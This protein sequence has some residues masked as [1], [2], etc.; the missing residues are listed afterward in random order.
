MQPTDAESQDLEQRIAD[1][2]QSI[3]E[4]NG[5]CH[6]RSAQKLA[7]DLIRLA[8]RERRLIP[9]LRAQ[10]DVVNQALH[11]FQHE[12]GREVAVEM[13]A[14]LESPDRA[15]QIQADFSESEF[16]ETRAWMTA[17]AYDNLAKHT[18][19]LYGYNSEGMHQCISDG[20][21][22]CRRTGKLACIAC[23]REYAHDVHLAADDI[24]MALHHIRQVSAVSADD[25]ASDRRWAGAMGEAKTLAL[26]GELAASRDGSIV[27]LER[28][29]E[30]HSPLYARLSTLVHMETVLW[31]SGEQDT[32]PSIAGEPLGKRDVPP[33]E[34]KVLDWFWD[35]RDAV[36]AC[37][38]GEFAQTIELLSRWDNEFGKANLGPYWFEARLRLIAAF[39]LAGSPEKLEALA[40]PL[41]KRAQK[42]RDFLTLRRLN[43]LLDP[44]EPPTPTAMLAS[45]RVGPFAAGGIT[46]AV[47]SHS[48]GGRPGETA[49]DPE[50]KPPPLF[51]IYKEMIER[52]ESSEEERVGPQVL[53]QLLQIQPSS[54]TDPRDAG[55]F[56][57]ML[58]Y[59]LTDEA[60][61]E[62]IWE[63]G[64]QTAAPT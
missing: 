35:A 58:P 19:E 22:V 40:G 24:E 31:L 1:M 37:C 2:K 60:P 45:P 25:A 47:E 15:R 61:F 39:R 10:F 6:D 14:L 55:A 44:K 9:L 28:S 59:L 33:G 18:G 38:Q 30:F 63:W 42:A 23:F 12:R 21:E 34:M 13:I 57:H 46:A 3:A 7:E 54:I 8:R 16:A 36:R 56:L 62:R 26:M 29:A 11:L 20:I 50:R 17:C 48:G 5:R 64:Q 32:F 49:L 51:G 27:A 41:V 4:L 43:R 53:E 52:L